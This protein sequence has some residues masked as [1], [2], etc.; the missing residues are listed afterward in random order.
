MVVAVSNSAIAHWQI[1]MT[2]RLGHL[3]QL[4]SLHEE[5]M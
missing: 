2:E 1:F 4:M 3:S 5:S